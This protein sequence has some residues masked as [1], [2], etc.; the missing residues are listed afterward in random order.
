MNNQLDSVCLAY[1]TINQ[2]AI[3]IWLRD[4]NIPVLMLSL[5]LPLSLPSTQTVNS[6]QT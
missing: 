6:I 1:K 4:W 5:G 3:W 2:A